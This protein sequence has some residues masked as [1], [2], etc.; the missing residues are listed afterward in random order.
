[1]ASKKKNKEIYRGDYVES[2]GLKKLGFKRA[3]KSFKFSF[4][5][6]KYA[7]L[8]EQSLTL[9]LI[10]M[11]IV[12]ACGICFR[13]STMQWVMIIVVGALIISAELFNTSI[14]AVVDMITSEFHPKAKAAKDTASAACFITDLIALGMWIYVFL[15]KILAMFR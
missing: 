2:L 1:M 8:H 3:L 13:I 10:V 6:L 14:E 12:I 5:G 9:H 11:F 15:P 7:Y 4:E